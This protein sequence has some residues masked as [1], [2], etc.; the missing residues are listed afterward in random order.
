[1]NARRFHEASWLREPTG[2]TEGQ[3]LVALPPQCLGASRVPRRSV[4]A[5][6]D[7]KWV[8]V[9]H[10]PTNNDDGQT[11]GQV[12]GWRLTLKGRF[13]RRAPGLPPH[14]EDRLDDARHR[15]A[16]ETTEIHRTFPEEARRAGHTCAQQSVPEI[17]GQAGRGQH[18]RGAAEGHHDGHAHGRG[19][20]HRAGVVGEDYPAEAEG[21]QQFAK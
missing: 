4:S 9:E 12:V 15:D 11:E 8:A 18:G 3:V 16:L 5:A 7:S 21:G 20:V 13:E 2:Q 6:T 14:L 10:D 17:P 1:M 19:G